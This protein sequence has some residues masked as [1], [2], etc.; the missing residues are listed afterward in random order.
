MIP[1]LGNLGASPAHHRQWH[2]NGDVDAY[3]TGM[4][5][6]FENAGCRAGLSKDSSAI[7]ICEWQKEDVEV[8]GAATLRW[9]CTM[10]RSHI[11]SC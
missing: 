8:L 6:P 11:C 2:G 4:N 10:L 5:G 3:L 9:T 7:A 1:H